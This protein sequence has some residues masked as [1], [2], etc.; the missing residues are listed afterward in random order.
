M[1]NINAFVGHSFTSEDAV[2][3]NEFLEYFKLLSAENAG[4]KWINAKDPEP[5]SVASK[6]LALFEG[7]NT[8]IGICTKKERVIAPNLL[9]K[10][11]AKSGLFKTKTI[12]SG[13][14]KGSESDFKWKTS[15]WLIQEIGLAIGRDMKIVLLIEDGIRN[16]GGLQSD[17]N[18]VNFDRA[19]PSKCFIELHKMLSALNPKPQQVSMVNA[20]LPTESASDQSLKWEVPALE[21]EDTDYRWAYMR[22]LAADKSEHAKEI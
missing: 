10:V 12:E 20:S 11:I 19:A 13:L 14:L 8:F 7:K 5:I 2:T 4:F 17:I 16:P 6:V 1:D 18:Y 9:T 21:W 3:I 15:D 22:L